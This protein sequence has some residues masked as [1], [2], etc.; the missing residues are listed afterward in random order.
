[1]AAITKANKFNVEELWVIATVVSRLDPV[2]LNP[3]AIGTIQAEQRL[4]TGP[5]TTPLRT[6]L[7][8]VPKNLSLLSGGNMKASVSP[9]ITNA[10][11]IPIETFFKYSSENSHQRSNKGRCSKSSIQNPWKHCAPGDTAI[12]RSASIVSIFGNLLSKRKAARI[13][14]MTMPPTSLLFFISVSNVR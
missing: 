1:M 6:P 3:F 13:I 8:P 12:A 14:I 4:T 9:A 7:N 2:L 5:M 10:N 11:N